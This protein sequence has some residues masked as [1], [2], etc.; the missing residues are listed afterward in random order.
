M[1]ID[2]IIKVLPLFQ[3]ALFLTLKLAFIGIFFSIIIGLICNLLLS[4]KSFI[5]KN[6]VSVYIELSRNT[7]LLIQLFFSLL[8]VAKIWYKTR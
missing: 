8:W 4:T 3:K 1:D 5:L 7:P 6:I 2:F